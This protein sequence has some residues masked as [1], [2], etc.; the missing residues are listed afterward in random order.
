MLNY[1]ILRLRSFLGKKPSSNGQ[2]WMLFLAIRFSRF[3]GVKNHMEN[4]QSWRIRSQR[5]FTRI[6]SW[7]KQYAIFSRFNYLF[8]FKM[9]IFLLG[10]ANV[11]W[12]RITACFKVFS[13]SSFILPRTNGQ[14]SCKVWRTGKN[15]LSCRTTV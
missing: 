7:Q 8:F 13:R 3:N 5:F 11:I 1:L 9:N 2:F 12:W 10:H 6:A 4:C 15:H 14:L